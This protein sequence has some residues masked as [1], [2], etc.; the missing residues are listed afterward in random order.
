MINKRVI[1]I[2]MY[3]CKVGTE[4]VN[5]SISPVYAGSTHRT[6]LLLIHYTQYVRLIVWQFCVLRPLRTYRMRLITFDNDDDDIDNDYVHG[7]NIFMASCERNFSYFVIRTSNM[8]WDSYF[9]LSEVSW[10][11]ASLMLYYCTPGLSW[12]RF[13]NVE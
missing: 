1:Y 12:V 9:R 7:I 13:T 10:L 8:R 5:G 4:C 3:Y 6:E 2:I 11:P